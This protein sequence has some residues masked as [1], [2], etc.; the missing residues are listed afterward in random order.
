MA[1]VSLRAWG[2]APVG[3]PHMAPTLGISH[4]APEH[5]ALGMPRH[6]QHGV[7]QTTGFVTPVDAS[8]MPAA[9]RQKQKAVEAGEETA[10]EHCFCVCFARC[11]L[12]GP[13]G[14]SQFLGPAITCPLGSL[15]Q[16]VSCVPC[17]AW[18]PSCGDS[19]VLCWPCVTLLSQRRPSASVMMRSK[20]WVKWT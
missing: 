6:P 10:P 17:L 4:A 2:P 14:T 20:T 13:A 16:G 18:S 12:Q 7:F 15:S 3:A 8:R 11:Y 9:F 5:G 1:R 19:E